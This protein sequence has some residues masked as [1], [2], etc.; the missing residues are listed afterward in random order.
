MNIR[1]EIRRGHFNFCNPIEEQINV[2]LRCGEKVVNA[3]FPVEKAEYLLDWREASILELARECL[4]LNEKMYLYSSVRKELEELVGY[5]EE[6]KASIMRSHWQNKIERLGDQGKK[7]Q[8]QL[9]DAERE[10]KYWTEEG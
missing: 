10:L 8:S 6:N 5:L 3:D 2:H 4:R 1:T 9:D 7:L